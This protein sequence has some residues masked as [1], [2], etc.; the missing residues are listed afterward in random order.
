MQQTKPTPSRRHL[1]AILLGLGLSVFAGGVPAFAQTIYDTNVANQ[2][3][4]ITPQVR[5]QIQAIQK[6]SK[7]QLMAVF[8]KYGIDPNA[9]PI[10]NKLMTAADDLRDV[11][12][13]ERTAVQKLLKPEEMA[14]YDTAVSQTTQRIRDAAN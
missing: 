8:Q 10:M 5:S 3:S 14:Q 4:G 13:A 1:R 12:R 7:V 9:K 6:Q 11:A 2:I